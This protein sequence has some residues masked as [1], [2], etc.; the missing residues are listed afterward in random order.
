MLYRL[1]LKNTFHYGITAMHDFGYGSELLFQ[2]IMFWPADGLQGKSKYPFPGTGL[3][4]Q[5]KR[6]MSRGVRW[7]EDHSKVQWI[8]PFTPECFVSMVSRTQAASSPGSSCSGLK[9]LVLL[10]PSFKKGVLRN[11]LIIVLPF[12]FRLCFLTPVLCIIPNGHSS[13]PVPQSL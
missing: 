13:Q 1:F 6:S 11:M 2:S 10:Y 8:S 12:L 5:R 9:P 4:Q 3:T 7:V